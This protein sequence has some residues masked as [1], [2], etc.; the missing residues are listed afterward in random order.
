MPIP[1][2]KAR[3][4][5]GRMRPP[6][7]C[8]FRRPACGRPGD[9][10]AARRASFLGTL[11]DNPRDRQRKDA[12]R[13]D[14]LPHHR[15]RRSRTSPRGQALFSWLRNFARAVKLS[16]LYRAR[17]RSSARSGQCPRPSIRCWRVPGLADAPL[18]ATEIASI[19]K[20]SS[21]PTF[22]RRDRPSAPNPEDILPFLFFRDGSRAPDRAGLPRGDFDALFDAVRQVATAATRRT[23]S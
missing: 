10:S 15:P 18:L 17:I 19:R 22:R 16:R 2:V 9:R 5:T 4:A 14:I 1:S 13:P 7:A 23:I 6:P 12:M 8:R 21:V 20:S 11:A 3:G